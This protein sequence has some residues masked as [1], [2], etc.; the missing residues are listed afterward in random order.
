[1]L[2]LGHNRR[3]IKYVKFELS[4]GDHYDYMY[5]EYYNSVDIGPETS[6]HLGKNYLYYLNRYIPDR[7]S[8]QYKR[9]NTIRSLM[10]R[11]INDM[12]PLRERVNVFKK[13][14]AYIYYNDVPYDIPTNTFEATLC[15]AN[16]IDG[17]GLLGRVCEIRVKDNGFEVD[18]MFYTDWGN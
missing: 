1:M 5:N 11:D 2:K 10:Q 4:D 13:C 12:F 18:Y 3:H 14:T 9:C 15:L 6:G 8:D 16:A 17:S 7:N